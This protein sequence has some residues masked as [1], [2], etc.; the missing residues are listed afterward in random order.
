MTRLPH[1]GH[2][3]LPFF[4]HLQLE[5]GLI[6]EFFVQ[7]ICILINRSQE[8]SERSRGNDIITHSGSGPSVGWAFQLDPIRGCR[9]GELSRSWEKW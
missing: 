3:R 7:H 6:Q 4:S 8:D 2:V 1:Q 9:G 5:V